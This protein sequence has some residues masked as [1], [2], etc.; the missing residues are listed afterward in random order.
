M[1]QTE[2]KQ[3][4]WYCFSNDIPPGKTIR[5]VVDDIAGQRGI[6]FVAQFTGEYKIFAA[7]EFD[8]FE[9]L[10]SAIA[11][12]Y[13]PAGLSSQWVKLDGSSRIEA[14]KRGSPDYCAI[15]RVKIAGDQDE[16]LAAIDDRFEERYQQD[17]PDHHLFSYGAC[18]VVPGSD[19]QILV[20][21]GADS[22]REVIRTAKED[23]RAV[24]GVLPSISMS[25]SFLPGNAKRPGNPDE[26]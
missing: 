7:A 17:E 19:F 23:L 20:D 12:N 8:E 18:T 6:R 9:E 15:V 25:L 16:V 21:L 3:E 26:S 11:E 24:D 13:G 4:Q 14:P 22:L 10:Q 2:A 1:A 5:Q